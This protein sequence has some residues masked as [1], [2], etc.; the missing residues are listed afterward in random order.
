[1]T[2]PPTTAPLATKPEKREQF[3]SH[4][5][6]NLA[7]IERMHR[8]LLEVV[9]HEFELVGLAEVNAVQGLL[10]FNIGEA[11]M[12]ITDLKNCGYY[13]GGSVSYNVNKLVKTGHVSA[14]RQPSDR[15][16]VRVKL[17]PK[18]LEVRN[19]VH[20]MLRRHC[21]VLQSKR[22]ITLASIGQVAKTLSHLEGHW[23]NQI[24]YIY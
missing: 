19:I 17:T 21:G 2:A 3:L 8:L 5:L 22:T 14:W 13:L 23:Q 4:Y 1:M 6:E 9:K 18:G 11:E 20:A 16:V 15:R 24:H 12:T 10:L 7:L